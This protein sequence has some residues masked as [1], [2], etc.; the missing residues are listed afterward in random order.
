MD[1][2][3]LSAHL[4]LVVFDMSGTTVVDRDE[5]LDCFCKATADAG[6]SATREELNAMMGWSKTAVFRKLWE[7]SLGAGHPE[8]AERTAH[9]FL[10]FRN[11]LESYYEDYP[12]TATPGTEDLFRW[13]RANGVAIA[14]TTGF[15]RE[16]TNTLL[17]Q[18]GWDRGLDAGYMHGDIID[19]SVT[20]D[21]VANGRPA[22]DMIFRAML[23]LNVQDPGRV[24]V[25]GDTPS[26]LQSGHAAGAGLVVGITSGSHTRGLLEPH[27]H[28]ALLQDMEH[29]HTFL[30]VQFLQ[31]SLPAND[32]LSRHA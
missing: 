32:N 8:I 25:I 30:E 21:E 13:L 29:F 31:G 11:L 17:R 15:Y 5:V 10:A 16:V 7:D 27:P 20:S 9:T 6:L 19:L 2:R 4:D 1:P 14:L 23:A 22:P 24:A 26:D 12:V 18:L 28:H 3:K